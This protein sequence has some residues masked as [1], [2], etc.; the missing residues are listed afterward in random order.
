M[1]IIEIKALEGPN[2]YS[3]KPVI[4]MQVDVKDL[5]NIATR[6]IPGFN[7]ALLS[8]LPGLAEHKCCFDRPGGFLIRLEEGTYFPHVLEHVAI[9]LLNMAGQDVSFGKARRLNGSVYNVIFGYEEKSSALKAASMAVKLLESILDKT[10]VNIHQW[11]SELKQMTV[12]GSLGPSTKAI[13]DEVKKMGIPVTRLGNGSILI[14]GYGAHQKRIEATI[15]QNTSCLAVD[16]ACDKML[17]K[18]LLSISGIP[19]PYGH[20]VHTEDEAVK[21]AE[22]I[23]YPVVI[24]PQ[25]GNQGKGVSLNLKNS[26]EVVRAFNLAKNYSSKIIVEKQIKGRHYRVLVVNGK[27][28]CASERIPAHVIGDGVSTVKELI[29][30]ENLDPRRGDHHEK[31]LTKIKIDPIVLNVLERSGLSLDSVPQKGQMVLLRDNGNLS[32]GGTAIDVTDQVC[33]E[34]RRLAEKVAAAIGLDIAGIDITTEHISIP[35][36][37]SGGAVI[38]VNAAPGIRM[39]LYPSQGKPRPVAKAIADML[40]PEGAPTFPLVAVTGTNGK[41][42]TVRMLNHIL[43]VAGYKVGMT[44]TDG[45]YIDNRLIKKGDCSGPESARQV[46]LDTTVEAAVLEIA[47]GGL[48]RGGLAY[49]KADIGIITNISEDHLGFDGIKTLEDMVFVKSLVAEQVK[50]TGYAVLNADDQKT[51]D[52]AKRLKGQI[53]FF[54]SQED[55]LILKKH[56]DQ[57]GRGV[58]IKNGTIFFEEQGR[59]YSLA[60]VKDLPS[61]LKGYAAHNVQNALAAAAGAWGLQIP[62]KTIAKALKEFRCDENQNPGRM[63]IINLENVTVILDYGHNVKSIEAVINTAKLMRPSRIIGVIASP[64]NRRDYDIIKLGYVAGKG[65]H[66]LIIKEDEDLRGRKPGEVAWLLQQGAQEAGLKGD[67]IQVILDEEEAI[68]YSLD[69]AAKGDIIVVFYENYERALAAIKAAAG[70]IK[71]AVGL[72]V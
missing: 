64:G 65:F 72:P 40:F 60:K 22:D 52:V 41:T 8:Y 56:L 54:S 21:A 51:I 28:C 39:H 13:A 70:R 53:I 37:E 58:Y 3:S 49:E 63:N 55:N 1:E 31:P 29:D 30:K 66:R 62:I 19:V 67:K 11:I 32:T 25:N 34:N 59:T 16:I 17:T 10:S 33:E 48:I 2:I 4:R 18:E 38:E 35:L 47:R 23:G 14:F 46:L 69:N 15:S 71:S 7:S 42:T 44:C 43:A 24:K 5:E 20:V 27:F 12:N 36:E 68:T 9:E 45:I 6:D 26:Q 50:D 61:A 57:G